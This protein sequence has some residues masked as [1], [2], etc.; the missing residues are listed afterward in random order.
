MAKRIRLGRAADNQ[1]PQAP[2]VQE[3][4]QP[5][6]TMGLTPEEAV[7]AALETIRVALKVCGD[8]DAG[9]FAPARRNGLVVMQKIGEGVLHSFKTN[10]T[11]HL[12]YPTLF[13]ELERYNHK[14]D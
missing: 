13:D 5:E 6:K 4:P 1:E 10:K 11:T 14:H 2:E 9:K 7:G 3:K 8:W 12:D